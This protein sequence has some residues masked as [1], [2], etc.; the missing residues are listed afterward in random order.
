MSDGIT[1]LKAHQTKNR[2]YQQGRKV[3]HTGILVHSTGAVNRELRRYVD[4]PD[5]LGKNQ[6][7]NHW[8]T[9]KADKAVHAFIGY[10]K[11]EKI[12]VVECLPLDISCWG[13]GS[14]K[15]GSFNRTHIQFEI[16]QGSDTDAAYYKAAITVAEKYC[17][18]LC[19]E[20]G[21]TADD[22]I[23]HKEAAEAGK[24]SNHGD[25]DS[26][27][28]KFGDSMDDF[29]ARVGVRL[30]VPVK[31]KEP[32]KNPEPEKT[33]TAATAFTWYT[34][35]KGDTLWRIAQKQ[36]GNPNRHKEIRTLNGMKSDKL[37]IGQRIKIPG[38]ATTAAETFTTYTVKKGDSL[39]TIAKEQLGA[40]SRYPDIVNANSLASDHLKIGQKL[41]IPKA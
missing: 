37:T 16:C 12:I 19:K 24:A 6:Y 26:W 7:N 8:N 30:G 17:A 25:P 23:S 38:K 4:A 5:R 13:S 34:V 11:D 15:N 9:E 40:G 28:K 1:I 29:R 31:V 22:I 20:R 36:L 18:H 33:E 10:D 27:M 35:K 21:W 14:G 3:N 2:C 39:W 32:E 41:K